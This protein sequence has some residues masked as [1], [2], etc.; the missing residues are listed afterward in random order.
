MFKDKELQVVNVRGDAKRIK[1]GLLD[2]RNMGFVE[3]F[4]KFDKESVR[5]SSKEKFS[6]LEGLVDDAAL[7]NSIR[8]TKFSTGWPTFY[9]KFEQL[10]SQK[11]VPL[12]GNL[13]VPVN[14]RRSRCQ[15]AS[16]ASQPSTLNSARS[17]IQN[18]HSKII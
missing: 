5:L 4:K 12:S 2:Y 18:R 11:F 1:G 3:F 17:P 9:D 7:L 13:S 10:V 15:R 8:I 6:K 16:P 14:Q